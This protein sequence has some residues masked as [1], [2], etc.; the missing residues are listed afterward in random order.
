MVGGVPD[1][2]TCAKFQIEIFMGYDFTGGR[3]FDFRFSYSAVLLYDKRNA[4]ICVL[5]H[6]AFTLCL[7]F[8]SWE[9]SRR[10]RHRSVWKFARWYIS[11]PDM[12]SLIL[13]AVSLGSQNPKFWSTK[14]EYIENGKSRGYV[15]V[16]AQNHLDESHSGYGTVDIVYRSN[17]VVAD[18]V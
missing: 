1:V 16:R 7:F 9:I 6:I 17:T 18:V 8:V 2:I 15:S 3:I 10:R 5:S 11:V 14:S 13:W 12:C 4:S